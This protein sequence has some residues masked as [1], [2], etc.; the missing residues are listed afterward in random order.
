MELSSLLYYKTLRIIKETI[1]CYR[2]LDRNLAG[3]GATATLSIEV[4]NMTNTPGL[5][6]MRHTELTDTRN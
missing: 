6:T 1:R 4:Q 5:C 2:D 3:I